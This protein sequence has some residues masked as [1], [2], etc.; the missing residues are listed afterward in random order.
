[1]LAL[2]VAVARQPLTCLACE[3]FCVLELS[4]DNKTFYCLHNNFETLKY[5]YAKT[6]CLISFKLTEFNNDAFSFL[7]INFLR[8]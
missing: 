2:T 1:M 6:I 4:S 5:C 7:N 3:T 8:Y